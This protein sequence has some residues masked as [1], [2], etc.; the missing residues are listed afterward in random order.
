MELLEIQGEKN[1]ECEQ[2]SE[3]EF[4]CKGGSKGV[5][6]KI[7]EIGKRYLSGEYSRG[8]YLLEFLNKNKEKLN[9]ESDFVLFSDGEFQLTDDVLKKDLARLNADY[10][11]STKGYVYNADN[12]SKDAWFPKYW[13]SAIKFLA[14]KT[15]FCREYENTITFVGLTQT[16]NFPFIDYSKSFFPK[17]FDGC[18]VEI[19]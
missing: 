19:K 16:D 11:I 17:L 2:D 6:A 9:I 3:Y 4:T 13:E 8:T 12:Y 10:R 1:A 7:E 14:S 18:E 5:L 15:D